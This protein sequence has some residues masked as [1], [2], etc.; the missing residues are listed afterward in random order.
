ML[1]FWMSMQTCLI[2][3]HI[4]FSTPLK[5]SWFSF[6]SGWMIVLT[7]LYSVSGIHANVI[8]LLHY[9]VGKLIV[10]PG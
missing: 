8:V 3:L 9:F 7:S 2:Y 10:F 4:L 6:A 1:T 5:D